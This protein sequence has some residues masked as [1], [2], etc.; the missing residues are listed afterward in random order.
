MSLWVKDLQWQL[1][2][3]TIETK[4]CFELVLLLDFLSPQCMFIAQSLGCTCSYAVM[5]YLTTGTGKA[6]CWRGIV[7]FGV[8]FWWCISELNFHSYMIFVSLL[9]FLR[10]LYESV[11]F[12]WLFIFF[13]SEF[14][15]KLL[16]HQIHH[17]GQCYE[18]QACFLTP[19]NSAHKLSTWN[20]HDWK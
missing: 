17:Y 14:K 7:W 6:V 4:K 20:C 9:K 3:A 13:K 11:N 15:I 2:T 19:L 8:F 10:V 18:K 5:E 1:F 16:N 12:I